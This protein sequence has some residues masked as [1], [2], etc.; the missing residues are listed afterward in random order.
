M[1]QFLMKKS[2]NAIFLMILII[3]L[4]CISGMIFGQKYFDLDLSG[5]YESYIGKYIMR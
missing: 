4:F 5:R 3:S 2:I 1:Q